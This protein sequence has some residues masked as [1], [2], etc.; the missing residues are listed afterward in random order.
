MAR[1]S[2]KESAKEK[3]SLKSILEKKDPKSVGDSEPYSAHDNKILL[4]QYNF[5]LD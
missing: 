2:A 4:T 3:V 5:T 1:R